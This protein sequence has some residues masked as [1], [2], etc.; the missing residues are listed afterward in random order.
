MNLIYKKATIDDLETLL[1]TRIEVLRAANELEDDINMDKV[2][3]ESKKYYI[4]SLHNNMHTAYLVFDND[5]FV[6]AGGISYFS[7]M[8]TYH[9]PTG[10]KAYIMNMYVRQDY[11]RHGIATKMLDLLVED[12]KMKGINAISLEAT[13]MGKPLYENYGFVKMEN[14]MELLA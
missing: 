9:N 5:S 10:K 12:A 6:G 3:Q 13:R 14:E 7:V 8:P 1:K 4:K 11:R 2:K